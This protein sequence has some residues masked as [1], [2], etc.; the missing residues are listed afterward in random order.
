[1]GN[2]IV[3]SLIVLGVVGMS[4]YKQIKSEERVFFESPRISFYTLA[5]PPACVE[6]KESVRLFVES[7]MGCKMLPVRIV[8]LLP[9]RYMLYLPEKTL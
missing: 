9:E 3:I 7:E 2:L 4:A 8:P 5:L 6:K 1:M